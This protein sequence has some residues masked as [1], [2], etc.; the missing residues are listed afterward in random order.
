MGGTYTGIGLV[1][2]LDLID[3]VD[4]PTVTQD[5]AMFYIASLKENLNKLLLK[6]R[7]S[8]KQV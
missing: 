8:L 6:N 7:I 3:K 4:F 1:N 5:G 2:G